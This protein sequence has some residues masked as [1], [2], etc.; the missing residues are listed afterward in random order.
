MLAWKI[1]N[2]TEQ[3]SHVDVQWEVSVTIDNN[4]ASTFG[5]IGFPLPEQ[6]LTDQLLIDLLKDKLGAEE[7]TLFETAL[8]AQAQ[9]QGS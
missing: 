6:P 3:D 7:L 8:T 5:Q 4:T 2:Y 1:K 9:Q